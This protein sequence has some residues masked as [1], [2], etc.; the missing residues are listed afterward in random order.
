MT[1][2][3]LSIAREL[4]AATIPDAQA[5]AIAS[6][7]GRGFTPDLTSFATK[8]DLGQL[9]SKVEAKIEQLRSSVIMWVVATNLTMAAVIIAAIK[10]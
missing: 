8:A 6:A 4:K 10:L 7:I 9:E 1:V 5:E 2:D 3:T